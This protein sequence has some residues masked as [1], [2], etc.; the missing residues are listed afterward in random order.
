AE[1]NLAPEEMPDYFAEDKLQMGFNF[2]LNQHTFLALARQQAAPLIEGLLTPPPLPPNGQWV[3]F[4]R[5]HDEVDLGRLSESQRADTYAAFGPEKRMQLY[6]RGIR[7][8]LAPMLGGDPQRLKMAYSLMLSLPGTPV[9]NYGEEIGMGDDLSL[10][11]RDSVRTPMQWNSEPNAGF[12][13]ATDRLIAPVVS[14]G[15]FDYRKINVATLRKDPDSLLSWLERAIRVRRENA[16]FGWGSVDIVETG[17]PA[18][19][20]HRLQYEGGTIIA[21]HN[22]AD[23]TASVSLDL[24]DYA[25]RRLVDLIDHVDREPVEKERHRLELEAYGFRWFRVA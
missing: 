1:A 14:G 8:R 19:F 24:S 9:I 12:S 10:K 17:D 22:L 21:V 15:R 6:D 25:G 18:V 20:G 3:T 4:L 13:T 5:N 2:V 16:E 23:S 11:E 7:R